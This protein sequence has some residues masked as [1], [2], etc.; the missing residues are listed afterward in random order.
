M[1]CKIM[2]THIYIYMYRYVCVVV[3]TAID[4]I[5]TIST[6]ILLWLLLL[7]LLV[8]F[9]L[10]YHTYELFRYSHPAVDSI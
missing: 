1:V 6:H 8:F 7:L 2:H 4:T 5:A 10:I 9:L 3:T